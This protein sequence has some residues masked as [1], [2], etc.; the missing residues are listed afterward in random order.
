MPAVQT[1]YAT[2]MQPGLEG[3]VATQL[4]DDNSETRTCETVAGIGF[5]RAV[6][7]GANARGAVLGGATKFIG[8]TIRSITEVPIAPN[9]TM[10]KY[11]QYFNMGVM[12]AGDMWVRVVAAVT[13]GAPATYSSSTGQLNPAS[14]GVAI[15]GS[16]YITSAGAGELAL[17]RL[18]A[19][20]AGA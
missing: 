1:T 18:T 16:R 19:P 7:E 5:G 12:L 13:H 6:S 14:A 9:T 15:A 4:N 11:D 8:L 10:D 20:A 3:Q 17:L 2:A